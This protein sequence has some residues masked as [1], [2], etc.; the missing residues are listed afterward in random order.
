MSD[1]LSKKILEDRQKSLKSVSVDRVLAPTIDTHLLTIYDDNVVDYHKTSTI[2][3]CRDSTQLVINKIFEDLPT[4][5]IDGQTYA[6]LPKVQENIFLPREKPVPEAK[7][8]TKWQKFAEMKGIKK[9][10]QSRLVYDDETKQWVPRWGYKSKRSQKDREWAIEMPSNVADDTDMFQKRK[11]A[12]KARSDKNEFQRLRNI[13]RNSSKAPD[14]SKLGVNPTGEGSK[15]DLNRVFHI[16]K[17][18]TASLGKFDRKVKGEDETRE[19]N[20]K[21]KFLNNTGGAAAGQNER[22]RLLAIHKEIQKGGKEGVLNVKKATGRFIAGDQ[23]EAGKGKKKAKIA[24]MKKGGDVKGKIGMKS[25]QKKA[26]RAGR[27]GKK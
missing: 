19:K 23:G 3:R 11:D 12:K 16:A 8:P 2:D 15:D 1:S 27:N 20:K 6:T 18:S 24:A 7:K 5:M 9:K 25:K 26:Q 17:K 22:D 10:K 14:T 13:A 21:R 4:E